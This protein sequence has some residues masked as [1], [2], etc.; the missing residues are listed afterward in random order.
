MGKFFLKILFPP[1]VSVPKSSR[2]MGIILRYVCWGTHGPPPP[3]GT[4]AADQ[5]THLPSPPPPPLQTP[6]SFRTRFGVEIRPGRPARGLHLLRKL[7]TSTTAKYLVPRIPLF[8]NCRVAAHGG[9]L[10]VIK[11]LLKAWRELQH[12]QRS[13]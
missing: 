8:G 12:I 13:L 2:V 6:T 5:P 9:Q 3:P 1:V 4:P 11:A 10:Q 7:R